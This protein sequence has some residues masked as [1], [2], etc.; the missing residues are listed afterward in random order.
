MSNGIDTLQVEY[1]KDV[2]FPGGRH[3]RAGS[4]LSTGSDLSEGLRKSLNGVRKTSP[5]S[6]HRSRLNRN[7]DGFIKYLKKFRHINAHYE[8]L[9]NFIGTYKDEMNKALFT[10]K[11]NTI[12][13]SQLNLVK[14]A[15]M[16]MLARQNHGSSAE[17]KNFTIN[18]TSVAEFFAFLESPYLYK[19]GAEKKCPIDSVFDNNKFIIEKLLTLSNKNTKTSK[20]FTTEFY[21]K[22][23]TY[24]NSHKNCLKVYLGKA[25]AQRKNIRSASFAYGISKHVATKNIDAA[26][27]NI[28]NSIHKNAFNK[29]VH[30]TIQENKKMYQATHAII[31]CKQS[32]NV[33]VQKNFESYRGI[34]LAKLRHVVTYDSKCTETELAEMVEY[35]KFDD[36]SHYTQNNTSDSTQLITRL[37]RHDS[38]VAA[39]EFSK[40]LEEYVVHHYGSRDEEKTASNTGKKNLSKAKSTTYTFN[41]NDLTNEYKNIN[42]KI[43]KGRIELHE[44]EIVKI[45]KKMKNITTDMSKA[46]SSLKAKYCINPETCCSGKGG[47]KKNVRTAINHVRDNYQL[48]EEVIR[49]FLDNIKFMKYYVEDI[50]DTFKGLLKSSKLEVYQYRLKAWKMCANMWMTIMALSALAG[51]FILSN[52]FGISQCAGAAKSA[53]IAIASFFTKATVL[54][55]SLSIAAFIVLVGVTAVLGSRYYKQ[56]NNQK[57]NR[58]AETIFAD[59]TAKLQAPVELKDVDLVV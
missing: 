51:T 29:L 58:E 11:Y 17:D 18:T 43:V 30:D 44:K 36:T 32:S 53:G 13:Q 59:I 57:H 20:N 33:Y 6:P 49:E 5:K 24:S 10:K 47:L 26:A 4:N 50:D 19:V 42:I 31:E 7:L 27:E 40:I 25:N 55:I 34:F 23:P 15:I 2:S 52:G 39:N 37:T 41:R 35:A 54:S 56:R 45:E 22:L 28:T 14:N 48:K 38:I 8:Y 16:F 1:V 46:V 3:E 21:G 12:L 9:Y